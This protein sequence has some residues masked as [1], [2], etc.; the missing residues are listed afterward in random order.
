MEG[1]RRFLL[2]SDI[3]RDGRTLPALATR[4]AVL[5]ILAVLVA[6]RQRGVTLTDLF[7][8]LPPRF[9]SSTLVREFPRSR[10]LE[11]VA[12]FKPED[13]GATDVRSIDR[14]DGV[15]ITF[16]ARRRD[17]SSPFGQCR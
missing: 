9:T 14:T 3:E 4:D 17:S 16:G 2:G 11:L 6:A 1:E 12:N 10:G 15:R 7:A 8:T 13:L 5:P